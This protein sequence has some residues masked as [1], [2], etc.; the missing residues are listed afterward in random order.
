MIT[1]RKRNK[2]KEEEEEEEKV[3]NEKVGKSQEQT[4]H[5]PSA[6]SVMPRKSG[7]SSQSSEAQSRWQTVGT[8][9]CHPHKST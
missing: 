9:T 6:V 3:S 1:Q 5:V 7:R 8:A 2:Q 4:R